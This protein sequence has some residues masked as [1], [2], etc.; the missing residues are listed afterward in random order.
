[1]ARDSDCTTYISRAWE[2]SMAQPTIEITKYEKM[3]RFGEIV[4]NSDSNHVQ[5]EHSATYAS[6]RQVQK[7]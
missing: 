2:R 5:K 7:Q 1:M 3:K 6:L 4:S